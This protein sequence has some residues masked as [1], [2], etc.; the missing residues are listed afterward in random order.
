MD[1]DTCRNLFSS[2][3][4][5]RL[6]TIG[7]DGPHLVPVTFAVRGDIVV[8]AVDHKPKRTTRLQRL[9]NIAADPAVTILVD[10]YDEDWAHLWWVRADGT[11][12]IAESGDLHA[13]AVE[14][15]AAKYD[16]Y[17][18]RRPQGAAIWIKVERWTGWRAVSSQGGRSPDSLS[19]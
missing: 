4:V 8:T 2:Q 14:L 15:L 17:R 11:A 1:P 18:T 12:S 9:V 3:P 10:H 7:G 16:H 6:A 5:A 19:G 13:E